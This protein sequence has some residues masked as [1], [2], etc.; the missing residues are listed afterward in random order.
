MGEYRFGSKEVIAV[1]LGTLLYVGA[2]WLER[3]LITNGIIAGEILNWV[4]IRI[5]IVSIIAAVYGP[6]VGMI[7]GVGGAVLVCELFLVPDMPMEAFIYGLYGYLMGRFANRFYVLDGQFRGIAIFDFNVVQV[8]ANTICSIMIA[9]LILF[10][11]NGTN[12]YE[13]IELGE[14]NAVGSIVLIGVIGTIGMHFISVH[15]K[16]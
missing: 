12:L 8:F 7:C 15:H 4:R 16:R 1:I 5:F 6:V 3:N 10:L 11:V 2:E 13:S 9:P 14:M